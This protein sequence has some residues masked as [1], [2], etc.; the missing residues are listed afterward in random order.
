MIVDTSALVA[1]VMREPGHEALLETL[2]D[3]ASAPGIGAPTVAELGLV[4][5]ARL[6]IDARSIVTGLLDQFQI[7]VVPFSDN[8]WRAAIGAYRRFGRGRHLAALNFGDC[9]TYAVAALAGQPLLFVG[10]DFTQTDLVAAQAVR[11]E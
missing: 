3:P 4:L 1:I 6:A 5:C 8:H 11:E 10:E 7:A 9:L 2:T